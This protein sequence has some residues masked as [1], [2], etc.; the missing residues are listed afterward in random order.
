MA[1][2]GV[3]ALVI[4]IVARI[5]HIGMM[6]CG[7]TWTMRQMADSMPRRRLLRQRHAKQERQDDE[8]ALQDKHGADYSHRSRA[9]TLCANIRVATEPI[10]ALGIFQLLPHDP[11]MI[12]P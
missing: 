4:M 8:E 12:L 3:L 9:P 10:G 2:R 6:R 5:Q 1:D 11:A 7:N